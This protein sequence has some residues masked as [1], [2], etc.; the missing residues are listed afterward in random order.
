MNSWQFTAAALVVIVAVVIVLD[1][2]LVIAKRPTF[3]RVIKDY[4]GS[5]PRPYWVGF[6]LGALVSHFA[7]W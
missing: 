4:I 5:D 1:L 6:L 7:N 3:S 2:L